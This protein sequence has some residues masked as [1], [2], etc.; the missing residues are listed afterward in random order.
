[1]RD[2]QIDIFTASNQGCLRCQSC[3]RVWR[4]LPP[5]LDFGRRRPFHAPGAPEQHKTHFLLPFRSIRRA[6]YALSIMSLTSRLTGAV[7][8]DLC[9][10]QARRANAFFRVTASH[11]LP[12]SIEGWSPNQGHCL[13]ARPLHSAL[14][15][16]A[17]TFKVV[18]QPGSRDHMYKGGK[19][20]PFNP[21]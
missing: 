16:P 4:Q 6:N 19:K 9:R 18:P 12:K 11:R 13:V 5:I 17:Q 1:M 8:A 10:S 15:R 7:P 14:T 2:R 3:G 20:Q 21:V